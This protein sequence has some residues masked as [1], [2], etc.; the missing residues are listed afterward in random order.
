MVNKIL[1]VI[2]TVVLFGTVGYGTAFMTW[3]YHYIKEWSCHNF[4]YWNRELLAFLLKK[5][6][7]DVKKSSEDVDL[8][9][10]DPNR[11]VYE[12][13]GGVLNVFY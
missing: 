3:C 9:T 10:N 5:D 11:D 13:I 4:A 6:V 7:N 2:C 12:K 8:N 1:K